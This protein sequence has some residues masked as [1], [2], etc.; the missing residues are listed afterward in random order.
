MKKY[1]FHD[2]YGNFME[3]Y[4]TDDEIQEVAPGLTSQEIE[5]WDLTFRKPQADE[6]ADG[7]KR[8]T[9]TGYVLTGFWK[10]NI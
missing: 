1:K 7:E 9:K 5:N 6:V 4:L 2:Q 10:G 8:I 3:C